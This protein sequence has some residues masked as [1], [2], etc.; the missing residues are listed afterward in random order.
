MKMFQGYRA[1]LKGIQPVVEQSFFVHLLR[2]RLVHI[3]FWGA[4]II[5]WGLMLFSYLTP[6]RIQEQATT[7]LAVTNELIPEGMQLTYDP[8]SWLSSASSGALIWSLREVITTLANYYPIPAPW[9]MTSLS[10]LLVI[11]PDATIQDVYIYDTLVLMTRDYLI[12]NINTT[13]QIDPWSSFEITEQV[14]FDRSLLL[15]VS[16]TIEAYLAEHAGTVRW[17]IVGVAVGLCLLLLPFLAALLTLW[18]TL[19]MLVI[20]LFGRWLSK[21]WVRTSYWYLFTG[22]SWLYLP[23]YLVQKSLERSF[24]LSSSLLITYLL[25]LGCLAVLIVRLEEKNS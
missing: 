24:I 19:I 11:D 22:L 7:I 25:M 4:V 20:T 8:V 15:T 17:T 5:V 18:V 23:I 9:G 1:I 14:I 3:M 2:Y 12:R 16:Q 10:N 21:L 13:V 6:Q